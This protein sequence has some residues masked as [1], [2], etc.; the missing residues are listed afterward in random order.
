MWYNSSWFQN[1]QVFS[2]FDTQ[3]GFIIWHLANLAECEKKNILWLNLFQIVFHTLIIDK[4]LWVWINN[5]NI[6]YYISQSQQ[7]NWLWGLKV[8]FEILFFTPRK[9]KW[10]CPYELGHIVNACEDVV[11]ALELVHV[12]VFFSNCPRSFNF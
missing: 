3:R 1:F 2:Y 5:T 6:V 10:V 12:L 4:H 9:L 8:S 11:N 7:T